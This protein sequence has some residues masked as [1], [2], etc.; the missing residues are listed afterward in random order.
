MIPVSVMVA[1]K[2]T[3]STKIKG[4]YGKGSPSRF[5]EELRPVVFWN[6]TYACNLRCEHCYIDAGPTPRQDELGR[7]RLLEVAEEMAELGIPLV[8]FSGGEPLLKP[9]FW[10]VA[11]LL[12]ERGRPKMALSSNGTL[13]TREVA[14]R[15][16]ELNFSYVGVSL[17]SLR[18]D[19]HD[20]F[21]GVQGAF[22]M[23]VRGIHN[24][25]EEGLDVGIRTTVTRWNYS[26]A[27][28]VVD[29]AAQL[30]ASRVSYYLLDS[31]GR[32]RNIV[33]ELPSPQQVKEF[34][35]AIVDKAKEYAGKVEV[36]LVRA[37]FA[38]IYIADLLAKDGNEFMDYLKLISAQGDC[39][40]KTISIYPDG[41]V[42]P[43]QFIDE[44]VIGD[45]RRQSLREILS[46]NNPELVKF[47]KLYEN[48]RGPRC[49]PCPFKLVCGGGSRGRAEA[50]SGD[51]W[52]DDPLCFIDPLDVWRRRG[53][54]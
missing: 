18:P 24:A 44:Y 10:D 32:A 19:A 12:S 37:N 15:L 23:T 31:I 6:I 5:S 3:V 14:R 35:D 40:R 34:V 43:C 39:G 52:G 42:R 20:K 17:D 1:G 11:R 2:G 33:S 29:L 28:K 26:E 53:Q 50:A 38:G 48:L 8:I 41:T 21:R 47:I 25:V 30:R 49:G 45:L 4:H 22:N 46:Y 9:E 13:I 51:F 27:P 36:E 54:G 7:G 16:K